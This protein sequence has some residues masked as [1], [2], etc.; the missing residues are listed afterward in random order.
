MDIKEYW[1]KYMNENILDIFDTTYEFFSNEI[2]ENVQEEYDLAEAMLETK[3]HHETAKE[4]EKV[5]KFIQLIKEKQAHIYQEN[6]QYFD[7][8]LIEYYSFQNESAKVEDAFSNFMEFPVQ[9]FDT[10]LRVFKSLIFNG[11]ID[12][13]DKA[14]I[15]NFD[16]VAESD[17]LMGAAEYDLAMAKFYITLEKLSLDFKKS[18][19]FDKQ[20]FYKTLKQ[21]GFELELDYLGSVEKGICDN[22]F[23]H[24]HFST[25]FIKNRKSAMEYLLGHFLKYMY[26]RNFNFAL[27]GRIWDKML[28][29]WQ[30]NVNGKQKKTTLD[31][32]FNANPD[33]FD[34][35]LAGLS[36]DIFYDN[37]PEMIATIWG[38]VYVY[39]FLQEISLIESMEHK[40][41]IQAIK[42]FKGIII[43]QTTSNLWNFNFVHKW[44]KPDS[45]SETEFVEEGKIFNKSFHFKEHEFKKFKTIISEEL[46]NIGDLAGYIV[47]GAKSVKKV[48]SYT[49]LFESIN[50]KDLPLDSPKK[51]KPT[52]EVKYV[53]PADL[54][55]KVGRND[56]CPCGSG[57]KYKKCCG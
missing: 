32:Y 44:E 13:I 22:E 55:N 36:G 46:E 1:D 14:I 31:K 2:P 12:L 10:Y 5:L 51:E 26:Q 45:I 57:K 15:R 33:K 20:K 3:G 24:E 48:P 6:F 18:Q 11:N 21:F 19:I 40:S 53:D 39:D 4:F 28:E 23:D 50:K 38:S 7:D 47:E 16:E 8:T 41:F 52:Q 34:K 25:S 49:D 35:F 17:K 54:G 37:K 30:S 9:N 56:P 29:F 42:K 27:S 43:A